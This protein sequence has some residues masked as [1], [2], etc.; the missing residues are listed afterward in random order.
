LVL[1]LR[2]DLSTLVLP[3]FAEVTLRFKDRGKLAVD[4]RLYSFISDVIRVSE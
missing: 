2:G 4:V 3:G 1:N